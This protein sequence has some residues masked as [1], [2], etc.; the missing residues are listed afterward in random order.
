MINLKNWSSNGKKWLQIENDLVELP[1]LADICADFYIFDFSIWNLPDLG[2][3]LEGKVTICNFS[4]QFEI[5]LSGYSDHGRE[6][7][8]LIRHA[9]GDFLKFA[10]RKTKEMQ[11]EIK[12]LE[13][14][15]AFTI[16][17]HSVFTTSQCFAKTAIYTAL[18]ADSMMKM[19]HL[20]IEVLWWIL[21]QFF[22]FYLWLSATLKQSLAND[23]K[24]GVATILAKQRK[25][26]PF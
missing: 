13:T 11:K 3:N 4:L 14:T 6:Q 1:I 8:A 9:L 21:G 17:M 23:C 15:G 20:N 22:I 12:S 16:E 19:F 24:L 5:K 26:K 25:K 7:I 18:V 10:K 2:F